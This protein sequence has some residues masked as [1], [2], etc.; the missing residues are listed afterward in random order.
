MGLG[1]NKMVLELNFLI[2]TD[3]GSRAISSIEMSPIG[4]NL[5]LLYIV[6]TVLDSFEII[7]IQFD[8]EFYV[9]WYIK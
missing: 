4:I 3:R 6:T 1:G 8:F 2:K 9:F 7:P 5:F